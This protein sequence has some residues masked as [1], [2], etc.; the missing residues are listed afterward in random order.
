MAVHDERDAEQA[1]S[2]GAELPLVAAAAAV[3]RTSA[4]ERRRSNDQLDEPCVLDGVGSFTVSL[5]ISVG[6]SAVAGGEGYTRRPGT[7][8]R[9]WSW[10]V[11]LP[12]H[13]RGRCSVWDA[14]GSVGGH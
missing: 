5:Y 1:V 14:D 12:Q 10:G 11:A 2:S 8:M 13:A 7:Y 4:A 3:M 6:R 9:I